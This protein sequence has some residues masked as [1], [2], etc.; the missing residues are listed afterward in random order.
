VGLTVCNNNN[1]W[2]G[3]YR[4]DSVTLSGCNGRSSP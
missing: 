2:L 4:F 1:T 3:T